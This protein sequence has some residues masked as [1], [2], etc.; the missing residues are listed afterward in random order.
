M[1]SRF[2]ADQVNVRNVLLF[3][4]I[5]T[6]YGQSAIDSTLFSR[7]VVFDACCLRE[8][9]FFTFNLLLSSLAGKYSC[10]LYLNTLVEFSRSLPD[11]S[12]RACPSEV[13]G[14]SYR[15]G[16]RRTVRTLRS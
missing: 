12:A 10:I 4:F 15:L 1:A 16:H 5:C 9:L 14:Y 11:D 7:S 6:P 8:T 13:L 2:L 3:S